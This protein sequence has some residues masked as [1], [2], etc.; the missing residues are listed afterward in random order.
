MQCHNT[1][2]TLSPKMIKYNLFSQRCRGLQVFRNKAEVISLQTS[3]FISLS[4]SLSPQTMLHQ[5]PK[6]LNK[7][8]KKQLWNCRKNEAILTIEQ[9]RTRYTQKTM[10]HVLR[11]KSTYFYVNFNSLVNTQLLGRSNKK[12]K[13]FKETGLYTFLHKPSCV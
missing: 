10:S 1:V 4:L 2:G 8:E 7:T 13:I 3:T 12:G 6:I 11:R 5:R 9:Q